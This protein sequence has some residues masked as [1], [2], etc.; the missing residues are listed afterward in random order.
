MK[1]RPLLFAAA[2]VC[3]AL[4]AAGVRLWQRRAAF[5]ADTGLLLPRAPATVC[6]V[7]L[8]AGAALALMA[9]ARWVAAGT[10]ERPG[11][12]ASFALPGRGWMLVYLAAGG[13]LLAAGL[14]GIRDY[15][16]GAVTQVSRYVFSILLVP[17]A[18]GLALV[19][20]LNSQRQEG[21][22]RFA[23]PLLLPGWCA[24]AWIISAYQAHTA[25][26]NVMSYA[27]YFLG[28]TAAAIGCYVIASFSFERP[29]PA[30]CLWLS[31][32]AL[33][34]LSTAV[35]D[36]LQEGDVHQTLVCL[37][38]GLYLLGQTVCLLWRGAVPAP[39]EPWT[40]PPAAEGDAAPTG[41]ADP[42]PTT[43]GPENNETEVSEHE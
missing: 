24:C 5:E 8:T 14:L 18:L 41:D 26:P 38:Y 4:A 37:G 36:G 31:G 6:L 3:L 9:L 43:A 35:A 32:T 12:L 23:W 34:L 21:A 15:Q 33:V 2:T 17:C 30:L 20:W 10:E 11:Y 39:L 1:K 25:Q 19:G 22:G 7:L 42:T 13:L 28:A 29:R 27:L 16:S 40:P